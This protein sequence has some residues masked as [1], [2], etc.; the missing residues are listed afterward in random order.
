[1]YE[2]IIS[3]CDTRLEMANNDVPIRMMKR[4]RGERRSMKVGFWFDEIIMA[5]TNKKRERI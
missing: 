3:I 2:I 1:L 4:T 5:P